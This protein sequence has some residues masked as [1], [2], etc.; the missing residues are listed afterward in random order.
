DGRRVAT[1]S[2]DHTARVWE[3]TTG[4]PVTPPLKHGRVVSAVAFSPDGR[5]VVTASDTARVWDATSGQPVTI[6]LKHGAGVNTAAFSSDGR[7]V[8]TAS[9]DHTARVWD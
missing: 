1:A 3:A 2:D 9:Y 7:R 6:P 4:Q 8:V 5:R